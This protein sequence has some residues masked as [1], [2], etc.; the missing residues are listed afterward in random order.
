[1]EG[2]IRAPV[3]NIVA[4]AR[5]EECQ[6][7]HFIEEGEVVTIAVEGVAEMSNGEGMEPAVVGQVTIAFLH[8]QQ[9]P[10]CSEPWACR[11][12]KSDVTM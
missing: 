4:Q 10:A 1:M 9:E 3:I 7:L 11:L 6:D 5:H 2:I 12:I 8:H